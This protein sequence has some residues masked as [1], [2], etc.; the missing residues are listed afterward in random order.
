[1]LLA[2]DNPGPYGIME[3]IRS[4]KGRGQDTFRNFQPR[5]LAN[6]NTGNRNASNFYVSCYISNN[7][8]SLDT[9][10]KKIPVY[11]LAAGRS[12]DLSLAQVSRTS[13]SGK[14][15]IAVIDSGNQ[16]AESN[17]VNNRAVRLIP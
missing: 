1:M 16:A 13:L 14:H 7:G 5:P 12:K 17:E 3:A 6:S 15:L 9:F 10:L 8:L 11:G 2:I 4:G